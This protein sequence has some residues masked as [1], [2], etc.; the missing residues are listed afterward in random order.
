[1]SL[2]TSKPKRRQRFDAVR[3]G[4]LCAG[5]LIGCAATLIVFWIMR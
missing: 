5:M 1:M 3:T 2:L 4:Y